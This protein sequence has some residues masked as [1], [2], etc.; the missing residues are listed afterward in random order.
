[1]KLK[2]KRNL[3]K[4]VEDR[5]V[6]CVPA[7]YKQL[8]KNKLAGVVKSKNTLEFG[9]FYTIVQIINN[10]YK[11]PFVEKADYDRD[12]HLA[13]QS[14][15]LKA[16]NLEGFDIDSFDIARGYHTFV[17]EDDGTTYR[18]K[19]PNSEE[20]TEILE[21]IAPKFK[22]NP[23]KAL[24]FDEANWDMREQTIQQE[25]ADDEALRA[26]MQAEL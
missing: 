19:K 24:K 4:I 22:V 1:M 6:K 9:M 21:D 10:A 7:D 5:L 12:V 13:T 17:L 18:G 15:I 16:F 20:L 25:L 11:F 23:K 3:I 26:K 8:V 14:K 2:E